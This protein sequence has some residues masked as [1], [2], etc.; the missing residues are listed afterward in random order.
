MKTQANKSTH[1][2]LLLAGIALMV[3][4]AA[5]V[6]ADTA[7]AALVRST[8]DEVLTVIK[9]N[10]DKQALRQLA[11]QKV[12]PCFDFKRMTQLAVGSGWRKADQTQQR[13][14]ESGFRALLVNT[15]T[16]ALAQSAAGD[17]FA[18][19]VGAAQPQ[20]GRDEA[21]VKTVVKRPGKPPVAIDYRLERAGTDWKVYDVIVEGVSLVLNYRDSFE[22]E[23]SRSGVAGLINALEEKNRALAK[24]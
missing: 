19:D 11:E 2:L 15:Y 18:V 8:V 5:G 22:S 9:Q 3:I 1:P 14:L 17:R 10:K 12:L 16:N 20:S 7:P 4:G 21:M 13:A 23:I 24:G 6:A